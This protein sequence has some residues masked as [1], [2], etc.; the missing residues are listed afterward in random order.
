MEFNNLNSDDVCPE[1]GRQWVSPGICRRDW[2][3]RNVE[4]C[5]KKHGFSLAITICW[6]SYERGYLMFWNWKSRIV[7][8]R[9]PFPPQ[10]KKGQ[11]RELE[12]CRTLGEWDIHVARLAN[13]CLA[14]KSTAVARERRARSGLQ[15]FVKNLMNVRGVEH[16]AA[17]QYRKGL[18]RRNTLS[19]VSLDSQRRGEIRRLKVIG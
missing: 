16:P 19:W 3:H 13:P 12:L 8:Y 6:A 17:L 4:P 7:S 14:W 10:N 15:I 18:G 11:F 9:S 2:T 1:R 5:E